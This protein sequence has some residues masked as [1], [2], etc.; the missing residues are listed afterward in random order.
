MLRPSE[1]SRGGSWALGEGRRWGH[2]QGLVGLGEAPFL[3]PLC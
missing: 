1:G 3:F 2:L